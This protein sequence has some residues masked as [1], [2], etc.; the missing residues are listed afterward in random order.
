MNLLSHLK[1][2][3][4]VSLMA[5]TSIFVIH[6]GAEEKDAES[7]EDVED[8]PPPPTPTS[9]SPS[10]SDDDEAAAPNF[11][12][13]STM[14]GLPGFKYLLTAYFYPHCHQCHGKGDIAAADPEQAYLSMITVEDE[15][16]RRV[17]TSGQF[18]TDECR[19]TEGD[20]ILA[21]IDTWIP[22]K[23]TCPE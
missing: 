21:D 18:C 4:A 15:T 16:L 20:P 5:A 2:I 3:C 9:T 22:Q 7:K 10:I 19:L 13:P 17:V 1:K 23:E 14:C 6:C 11:P 8:P 12:K